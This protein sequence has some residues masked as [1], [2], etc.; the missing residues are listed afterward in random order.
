[1]R[2]RKLRNLF[3]RFFL[4]LVVVQVPFPAFFSYSSST[5]TMVTEGHPK[6]VR[7]RRLRNR[8]LATGSEGFPPFSRVVVQGGCS[9]RRPRLA[10]VICPAI[11]IS[12]VHILFSFHWL[13]TPFTPF[14]F[15]HPGPIALSFFYE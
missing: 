13:S 3:P 11:F 15:H 1:M 8:K 10:L 6:G 12:L 7:N 9:L 4:T 14:Y 5:S 2:K